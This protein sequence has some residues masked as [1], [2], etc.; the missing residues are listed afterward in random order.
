MKKV[1]L[2]APLLTQSGYGVHSR[3]VFEY[4]YSLNGDKI[5]LTVEVLNWGRTSWFVN[6]DY[7]RGLVGR[8]MSCSKPI[9]SKF[10]VTFQVQL[11]DE[12]NKDLG[13]KNIGITAA[14]ETDVCN[15]K[16]VESCNSMDMVVVPSTFTKEVIENSGKINSNKIKVIPEWFSNVHVEKEKSHLEKLA[17]DNFKIST[18]LNLMLIGQITGQDSN[19]DRKNIFY[20][21]KW[22]CETFKDR[23]DVGLV[24]K[25]NSGKST[26]I[27]RQITYN[28]LSKVI[29]EVRSGSFPKIH[30]I[31]GHMTSEEI[32]CLY[33]HPKVTGYLSATRGE[34]Y[35]LPT[36]DAAAAGL[37]I[38]TTDWSGHLE[39]LKDGLFTPLKYTLQEIPD[40]KCDKRIF[41]KGSKWAVVNEFDFKSKLLN[42]FDDEQILEKRQKAEKLSESV[43]EN[44]S[45]RAI[46]KRYEDLFRRF[47]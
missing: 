1:L 38:I 44:F 40:Q 22:F 8:I 41:M 6:P 42:F 2:R 31:H 25:T 10:D 33:Y 5:D 32:A 37:P 14:V 39:Y 15:P 46:M 17:F 21:I 34:G 12:W 24:L 27:D 36:I 4:L 47:L 19:T 29:S 30:F 43:R 3:Q 23:P 26:A 35:G 16:W 9:D 11:P 7:E 45:K 18:P 20:T 28:V 13:K